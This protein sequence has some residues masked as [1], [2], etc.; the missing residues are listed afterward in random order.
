MAS[1]SVTFAGRSGPNGNLVV[2][3]HGRR[4]ESCYA[5]LHRIGAGIRPGVRVKQKQVIG[6][7]GSTGRATGPHLHFAVR[8]DGRYVNPQRLKL[9]RLDPV[10]SSQRPA[11][12]RLVSQRKQRLASIA[13]PAD[14]KQAP[15]APLVASRTSQEPAQPWVASRAEPAPLE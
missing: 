11:F 1:G 8:R 6:S 10:S 9:S 15:A 12:D 3:R 5:H 7:V 4:L 14:L 2:I 13:L